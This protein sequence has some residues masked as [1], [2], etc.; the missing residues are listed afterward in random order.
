MRKRNHLLQ[1][2]LI[3]K[4]YIINKMFLYNIKDENNPIDIR[5]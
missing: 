3:N 1:F 2:F 4:N 5:E